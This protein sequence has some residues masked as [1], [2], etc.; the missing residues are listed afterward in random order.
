MIEWS[1]NAA[2]G[3]QVAR[4]G[5]A[6][7]DDTFAVDGE[8]ITSDKVSEVLRVTLDSTRYYVKRYRSRG[9]ALRNAIGP[10]RIESEWKNLQRFADWGIPTASVVANGQERRF[11]LFVRGAMVTEEI[12][13]TID[14]AEFASK[15]PEQV[16]DRSRFDPLSRQVAHI[17][18]SL[19]AHGFTHNDLFWRNLLLHGESGTVY[20]I[21]CPNGAFWRGPMLR[22]RIAKDLSALDK[23]ARA[24]LRRS[25][26]MRFLLDYCGKARLDA[27]AKHLIRRILQAHSRRRLRKRLGL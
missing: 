11:G 8:P 7:L 27:D 14:L 16:R 2:Y 5:F 25:Q 18:R 15:Q 17:V 10:S 6:S 23:R 9:F 22:Y 4:A 21:D 1:V 24:H 12:A 13:G 19:H 3:G 26:R 20:L